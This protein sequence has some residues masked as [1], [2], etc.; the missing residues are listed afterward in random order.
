M[1]KFQPGQSGNPGGKPKGADLRKALSVYDDKVIQRLGELLDSK[2]DRVALQA[3]KEVSDRRFGKALTTAEISIED[4][5]NEQSNNFAPLTPDEVAVSLKEL[6]TTAER[7]MG[8]EPMP[9]HSNK[10]RVERLLQQP[11]AMSPTLYGAL[12]QAGGTRH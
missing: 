10:E 6:L 11:G 5:R 2:D 8:L 9:L 7:E 1:G 3:C 12:H 4:N